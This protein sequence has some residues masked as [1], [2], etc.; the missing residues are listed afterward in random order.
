MEIGTAA[1]L[2]VAVTVAVTSTLPLS[3]SIEKPRSPSSLWRRIF[4]NSERIKQLKSLE[5]VILIDC[6]YIRKF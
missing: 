4:E 5:K 2:P 1:M 6:L 3:L